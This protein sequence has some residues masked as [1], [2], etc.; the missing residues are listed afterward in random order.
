[1]FQVSV[2][3]SDIRAGNLT[4]IPLQGNTDYLLLYFLIESMYLLTLLLIN[5]RMSSEQ[6]TE[7]LQMITENVPEV[8]F[9]GYITGNKTIL[10]Y[11]EGL[12]KKILTQNND[13]G[14]IQ[15]LVSTFLKRYQILLKNFKDNLDIMDGIVLPLSDINQAFRFF[16]SVEDVHAYKDEILK[17]IT[18]DV[19][20]TELIPKLDHSKIFVLVCPKAE[21]EQMFETLS[22]NDEFE[23]IEPIA[24]A[25]ATL[26]LDLGGGGYRKKSNKKDNF[27]FIS[28]QKHHHQ[29]KKTI[30]KVHIK[31][32]KGTKSVAYYHK[33]KHIH[34]AKKPLS[35][36]EIAFIKVGKFIPGLFKDCPCNKK[37]R[38][39]NK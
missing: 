6:R 39:R 24:G 38:R 26:D 18:E 13:S 33:G 8:F 36:I 22:T 21:F 15:L 10:T 4:A 28:H 16:S 7:I 31:N 17:K 5:P 25:S 14:N 20:K 23:I 2:D 12:F 1:L 27:N 37:T 9:Y 34:T 32:G 29:G 35:S 3:K 11:V 30:R 19:I